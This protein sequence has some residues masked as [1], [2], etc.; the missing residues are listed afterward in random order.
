MIVS[1]YYAALIRYYAKYLLVCRIHFYV[2]EI[3]VDM[4]IYIYIVDVYFYIAEYSSIFVCRSF[5]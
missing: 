4:Y 2:L 5:C 3:I 1:C